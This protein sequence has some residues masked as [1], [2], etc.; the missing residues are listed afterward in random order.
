MAVAG[1]L[2]QQRIERIVYP[3]AEVLDHSIILHYCH[4]NMHFG[5]DAGNLLAIM[6]GRHDSGD[7]GAMQEFAVIGPRTFDNVLPV[8]GRKIF[9]IRINRIIKR[10]RTIDNFIRHYSLFAVGDIAVHVL[11]QIV[12]PVFEV[13]VRNVHACVVWDYYENV[14]AA[15]VKL[16][17]ERFADHICVC[18]VEAPLTVQLRIR[19]HRLCVTAGNVCEVRIRFDLVVIRHFGQVPGLER[20]GSRDASQQEKGCQN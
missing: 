19:S 16:C 1:F 7:V 3:V 14:G 2:L 4:D 13:R 10:R 6:L 12:D 20:H 17:F 5:V 9:S 11:A 15:L 18:V 8:V